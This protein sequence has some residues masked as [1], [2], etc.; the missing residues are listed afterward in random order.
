VPVTLQVC[1][2]QHAADAHEL[3]PLHP[4]VHV[5]VAVLVHPTVDAQELEPLH[6]TSQL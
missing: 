5:V 2:L 4:I 3:S 1:A 6:A